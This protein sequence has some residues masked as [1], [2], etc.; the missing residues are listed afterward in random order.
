V[1]ELIDE[2][3]EDAVVV[4]QQHAG[5]VVDLIAD[6]RW[7]AGVARNDLA[8]ESFGVELERRV[9]V[10]D[11]LAGTPWRWMPGRGFGG[12][13]RVTAGQPR[14]GSVCRGAEND[15]NPTLISAGGHRLQP[16]QGETPR[17]PPPRG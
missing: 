5:L 4:E 7:M 16:I 9:G 15:S 11:L 3:L 14:R 1:T 10:V 2:A 8:D 13:L 6:H 12:D 17:P